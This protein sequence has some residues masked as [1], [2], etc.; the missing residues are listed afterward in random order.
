MPFL[1]INNQPMH[2]LDIGQG[3]PLLFGHNFMWDHNMWRQQVMFFSQSYRCIL[4]DLWGH[5]ESAELPVGEVSIQSLADDHWSL[6]QALG[7]HQFSMIGLSLGGMW[8]VRLALDHPLAVKCLVLMNTFVGEESEQVKWLHLSLL[9]EVER[10]GHIPPEML[11]QIQKIFLSPSTLKDNRELSAAVLDTLEAIQQRQIPS[12]VRLGRAIFTRSDMMSELP[13]LTM[14]TLIMAG[15]DDWP[16]PFHEAEAMM[17]AIPKAQLYCIPNAGHAVCLEQPQF[18]NR[19]LFHFL[20]S[21]E[22]RVA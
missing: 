7:L 2:Y 3:E 11:K 9:E 10:L 8:G 14:P 17:S 22:E 1:T 20:A 13:K 21:L 12:L 16:R 15:E 6:M 5:G 18:V 19:E 4:P